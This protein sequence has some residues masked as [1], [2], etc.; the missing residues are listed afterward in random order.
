MIPE[1]NNNYDSYAVDVYTHSRK[2]LGYAPNFYEILRFFPY[3]SKYTKRVTN[4]EKYQTNQFK[5]SHAVQEEVKENELYERSIGYRWTIGLTSILLLPLLVLFPIYELYAWFP[6]TLA[7]FFTVISYAIFYRPKTWKGLTITHEWNLL[8]MHLKEW[9]VN[10]W[11]EL[12]EDDKMHAYIYGL[13][14]KNKDIMKNSDKLVNSFEVLI[15]TSSYQ[16]GAYSP[17]NFATIAYFGPM[18]STYFYSAQKRTESTFNSS[19]SGSSSSGG[20]T[21]GGGSGAF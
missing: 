14:I 21:G 7:L 6:F 11:K 9:D 5:W 2:Q 20:G 12:P 13:G 4:H 19:S 10:E 3:L 15:S 17:V 16:C 8:K 1:P 18:A